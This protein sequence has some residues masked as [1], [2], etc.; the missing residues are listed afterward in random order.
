MHEVARRTPV[1][2][3]S[4]PDFDFHDAADP[5]ANGAGVHCAAQ[6]DEASA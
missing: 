6:I 4:R 5:G 3:L 1:V 2:P